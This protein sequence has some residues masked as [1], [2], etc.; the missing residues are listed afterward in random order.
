MPTA[1]RTI[2]RRWTWRSSL[3]AP[4]NYYTHAVLAMC[5]AQLG[6]T[7]EA[8]KALRDML[9][10]KPNYAEVA[11]ELHGRWIDPDLVEQ[12]MDGLRKAGLE[13]APAEGAAGPAGALARSS[14]TDSGAVRADEGF[15]VA[16][17]P[18]K[19]GGADAVAHGPGRGTDRGD[20]DRPVALLLP[21]GDR[22]QLDH[23]DGATCDRPA[24]SSA[25]AT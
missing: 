20:R 3:N 4:Q 18:F 14:T 23:R 12:L 9:A 25:R 17:L 8:R 16:V 5:Y 11:R 22:A 7:E 19:Y 1:R 24:R 10:L 15:W 21:Q 13:I 2:A 6:Q